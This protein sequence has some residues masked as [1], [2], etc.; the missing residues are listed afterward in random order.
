M[1]ALELARAAFRDGARALDPETF[2]GEAPPQVV[3]AW[4]CIQTVRTQPKWVRAAADTVQDLARNLESIPDNDVADWVEVCCRGWVQQAIGP[5]RN[6]ARLLLPRVTDE[7]AS[8]PALLGWW[9]ITGERAP[10]HRALAVLR[11]VSSDEPS[12][13]I[14]L[15]LGFQATA[16]EELRRRGAQAFGGELGRLPVTTWTAAADLLDLDVDAFAEPLAQLRVDSTASAADAV[17]AMAA[18]ALP[19]LVLEAQWWMED[20]LSEGPMAE[21]ATF[22]WPALRLRFARL[23]VMD[24]IHF[25]ARFAG[26]EA[27]ELEDVGVVAP[28]LE[29]IVA[30]TDRGPLLDGAPPR[31]RRKGGLRR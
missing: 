15:R 18:L 12:D 17:P 22:P 25:E 10:L 31:M 23:S 8:V 30:R 13:G 16:D 2:L 28:W 19:T 11:S 9:R 4:L 5:F 14:A 3:R 1:S 24:Q 26:G 7:L 20:E 6:A 21:A 27:E 29:S